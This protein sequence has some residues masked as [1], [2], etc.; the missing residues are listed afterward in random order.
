MNFAVIIVRFMSLDLLLAT[1]STVVTQQTYSH[2]VIHSI[3][4]L[5]S[6]GGIDSM[7]RADCAGLNATAS[8]QQ[9]FKGDSL[10]YRHTRDP[11]F[12]VSTR[13]GSPYLTALVDEIRVT[14]NTATIS[15]SYGRLLGAVAEK[16]AD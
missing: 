1:A 10:H 4:S 6:G 13:H 3:V 14:G 5:P 7:V 12:P 11:R 8:A 15:G 16:K 9:D 2:R